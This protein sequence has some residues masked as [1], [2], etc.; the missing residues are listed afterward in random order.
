MT[1]MVYQRYTTAIVDAYKDNPEVP[2][3]FEEA[4]SHRRWLQSLDIDNTVKNTLVEQA[5]TIEAA[6]ERLNTRPSN[7]DPVRDC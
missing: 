3:H 7:L 5:Q 4:Q 6:F 1:Y 2:R